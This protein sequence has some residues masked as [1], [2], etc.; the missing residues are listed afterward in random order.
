MSERTP[1][2]G[3]ATPGEAHGAP[4][5]LLNLPGL[6]ARISVNSA[7]DPAQGGETWRLRDGLNAV[8]E[9]EAGSTAILSALTDSMQSAP[10]RRACPSPALEAP[11]PSRPN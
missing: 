8:A 1:E 10:H 6:S 9:G 11:R 5:D 2:P 7:V 4:L 3:T